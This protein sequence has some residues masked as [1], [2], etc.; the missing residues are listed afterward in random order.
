MRRRAKLIVDFAFIAAACAAV[1]SVAAIGQTLSGDDLAKALQ[2]GGYVIVM[3]HASSPSEPPTQQMANPDN[4]HRERQLDEKGR[5]TATAMGQALLRLRI[6]IGQVYTSPTY[7]ALE[8]VRLAGLPNAQTVGDLGDGG[9]S[10]KGVTQSQAEWLR[11]KAEEFH[12]GRNTI[13]VTHSPNITRAFPRWSSGLTDGEALIL[14]SDGKGGMVLIG[15][16]KIEDWP[17]LRP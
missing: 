11:K 15:R 4:V 6:P 5:V 14:G 17:R 10:M 9:Q 3:R 12:S 13:I 1:T 2:R 7:R 8:T 16:I